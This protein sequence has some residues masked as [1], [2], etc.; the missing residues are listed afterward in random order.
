MRKKGRGT[1][2]EKEEERPGG[3]PLIAHRVSFLF[4]SALVPRPASL[5]PP[6]IPSSLTS[7]PSHLSTNGFPSLLETETEIDGRA[8]ASRRRSTFR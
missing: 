4:F 6:P 3:P 8:F 1:R 2:D 7:F 5:V